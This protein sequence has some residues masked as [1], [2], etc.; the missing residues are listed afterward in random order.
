[1]SKVGTWLVYYRNSLTATGTLYTASYI[2]GGWC[3]EGV[4]VQM[5]GMA[6]L[7]TSLSADEERLSQWSSFFLHVHPIPDT[8]TV[9]C[10]CVLN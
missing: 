5:A 2:Q 1:M 4:A 8:E 10:M 9:L 6:I 3:E 7:F